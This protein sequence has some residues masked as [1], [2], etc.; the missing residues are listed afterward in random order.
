MVE[1][2]KLP[3]TAAEA[4]KH[5]KNLSDEDV[6]L[7][8]STYEEVLNYQDAVSE[9]VRMADP[10][11]YDAL[12]EKYN[13]KLENLDSEYLKQTEK[14]QEDEDGQ[15]DESEKEAFNQLGDSI[16]EH[17][18][19]VDEIEKNHDNLYSQLNQIISS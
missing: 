11:S 10:E 1:I 2:L 17:D 6:N 18:R 3:L 4:E 12:N 15:M 19:N 5:V 8:V 14:L 7:L 16:K 13:N 9:S